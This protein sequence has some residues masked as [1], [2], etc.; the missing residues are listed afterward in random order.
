MEA[1]ESRNE[2]IRTGTNQTVKLKR[3]RKPLGSKMYFFFQR[4]RNDAGSRRMIQFVSTDFYLDSFT[5]ADMA[6]IENVFLTT[7][8]C[9]DRTQRAASVE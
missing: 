9:R 6:A 8:F 5:R 4:H 2:P 1:D 7:V 3:T